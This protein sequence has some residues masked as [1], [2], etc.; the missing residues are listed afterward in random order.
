MNIYAY[1]GILEVSLKLGIVFLLK[2]SPFDKLIT[3]SYLYTLVS[4]L[5]CLIYVAYCRTHYKECKHHFFGTKKCIKNYYPFQVG[6]YMLHFH[7]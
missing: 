3:Y 5:I 7:G 6:I 1:V 4:I 2:I